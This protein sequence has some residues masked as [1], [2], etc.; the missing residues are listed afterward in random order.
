MSGLADAHSRPPFV[1]VLHNERGLANRVFNRSHFLRTGPV[2]AQLVKFPR[3]QQ[4]RSKKDCVLPIFS[5]GNLPPLVCGQRREPDCSSR[6]DFGAVATRS[7]QARGSKSVARHGFTKTLFCTI[8]QKPAFLLG[9]SG[10][11]GETRTPDPLL[12][13]HGVQKSKCRF[14][15]RIRGNASLISPL[16]W[17]ED[18][19]NSGSNYLWR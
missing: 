17:T 7:L 11:P 8:L 12:R 9:K 16:N 4:R 14:W 5:H 3:T 10:A 18:G 19:L 13:R 15:C 6:Q 1:D 2:R